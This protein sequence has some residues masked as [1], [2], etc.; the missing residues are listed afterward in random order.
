MKLSINQYRKGGER[1]LWI[2]GRLPEI[3][4]AVVADIRAK[5]FRCWR[6]QDQVWVNTNDIR[7]MIEADVNQGN[8]TR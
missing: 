2:D 1:V 5:G 3:T 7:A 6:T 4:M 8:P